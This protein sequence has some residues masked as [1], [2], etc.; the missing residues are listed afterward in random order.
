MLAFKLTANLGLQV[1]ILLA[2]LARQSGAG[3]E[4][5][6]Q[7]PAIVGDEHEWLWPGEVPPP[8]S[9]DMRGSMAVPYV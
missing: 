3:C 7:H 5:G 4:L 2:L 8:S 6:A 1:L 9:S